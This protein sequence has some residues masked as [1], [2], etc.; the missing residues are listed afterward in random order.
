[1]ND[2][3]IGGMSSARG[4][5]SL[6]RRFSGIAASA[7]YASLFS[8]PVATL[9]EEEEAAVDRPGSGRFID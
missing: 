2:T 4:I 3:S 8:A 6:C 9:A 1:L 7:E 5:A